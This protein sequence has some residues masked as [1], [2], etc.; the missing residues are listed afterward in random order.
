MEILYGIDKLGRI[1][2]GE[3]PLKDVA[4]Y[5]YNMLGVNAKE[6]YHIYADMKKRKNESRIYFLD[7]MQERLNRRMEMNEERERKRR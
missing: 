1:N 7:K 3:T 4:T 5:F 2:V 6:C